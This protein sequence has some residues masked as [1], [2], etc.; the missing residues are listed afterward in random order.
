LEKLRVLVAEDH[1]SVRGILVSLLQSEFAVVAA[2]GDGE[3][4]VKAADLLRPDVIVSDILM[5]LKDGLSARAELLSMGIEVPF[6]F[7]T[8]MD[9]RL[10]SPLPGTI[11]Y[12]HKSDLISELN[13]SVRAVARGEIYLSRS[14]REMWGNP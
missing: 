14:F 4:L 8:L 9:P 11:S 13:D 1:D 2:I 12:I 5:P 6:V 7:V 10:L 3:K